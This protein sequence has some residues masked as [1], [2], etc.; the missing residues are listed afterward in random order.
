MFNLKK[1]GAFAAVLA[2]AVM[3]IGFTAQAADKKPAGGPESVAYAKKLWSAMGDAKLIGAKAFMTSP[4][5]GMEP[6]GFVL[7]TIDTMLTV[8]GHTGLV[9]V[10]KNYGPKGVTPEQVVDNPK[11]HLASVTV[12]FKREKGYDP[13]DKDWFW[14][15][16]KADGSLDK[17]PAGMQLAGK[18][19]KGGKA[20]CIACHKGA[21]GGD[22]V[23]T[24][25]R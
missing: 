15:K 2:V 9:I 17:N 11:K 19:V 21:P 20:G 24:R 23:F 5:E 18:V 10:K 3:S 1:I 14:A 25:D 16:Y 13:E 4:Y 6:H 7:E 8:G 22:M 12:M